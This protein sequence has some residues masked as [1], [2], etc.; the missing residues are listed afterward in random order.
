VKYL[1]IAGEAS[2]DLH[3]SRVCSELLKVDKEA[4]IKGMG[5]KKMEAAGVKLLW[6]YRS[7]NFMGFVEVLQNLG[8]IKRLLKEV[9][10]ELLGNTPDKVIL[11]DYGGFNL[12]IARFCKTHQ[13]ETHFYILPKV[14]AW[15]EKR[16]HKIRRFVDFGYC[17]FPFEEDYFK[18]HGVNAHYVGNPVVEQIQEFL[19]KHSNME[20]KDRIALLPGSRSQEVSRI[21]PEMLAF[22]RHRSDLDFIIAA[23]DRSLYDAA[24]FPDNVAFSDEDTYTTVA[25][26]K[27]AIVTS[28]TANLETALLNT[29]QVVCYK[30]N[31]LSYALGKR[32][33]KIN[34][35]SP[36]NLILDK[37]VIN[38]LIQDDF[39]VLHLDK[40]VNALLDEDNAKRIRN[41]YQTLWR[42]LGKKSAAKETA[43]RI[44]KS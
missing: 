11:I 18:N 17:I 16:V 24:E 44:I 9:K 4:V 29:P 15:N 31:S 43:S 2:G 41:D 42:M 3:A 28:G 5:G 36:V 7:Y 6:D 1:V 37:L 20:V 34:Y 33:V 10:A 32:L 39:N 30:A 35:I 8:K 22:A 23:H 27:A 40:Q 14:W 13:I 21:L 19:D 26:S 38:E 25:T 12:K